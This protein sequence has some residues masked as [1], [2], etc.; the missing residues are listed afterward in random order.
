MG[1]GG[2]PLCDSQMVYRSGCINQSPREH[3][4]DNKACEKKYSYGR[5]ELFGNCSPRNRNMTGVERASGCYGNRK[6]SV[7]TAN[8]RD[9]FAGRLR[10]YGRIRR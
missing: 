3:D 10:P 6:V 1:A 8:V 4:P 5:V 2:E 7:R 9:L